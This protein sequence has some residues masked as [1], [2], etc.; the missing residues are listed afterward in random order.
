M[1]AHIQSF[2]FPLSLPLTLSPLFGLTIN[3][4]ISLVKEPISKEGRER[5]REGKKNNEKN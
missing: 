5:E 3:S 2:A 4:F 1:C